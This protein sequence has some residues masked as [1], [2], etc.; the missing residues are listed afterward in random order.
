MIKVEYPFL[1]AKPTTT[2]IKFGQKY[3]GL[4]KTKVDETQVNLLLKGLTLQTGEILT[5]ERIITADFNT[6]IECF[7]LIENSKIKKKL[8]S[9]FTISTR[10]KPASVYENAQGNISEFFMA[11]GINMKSC[12]YCN[13]DFINVF[14]ERFYYSSLQDFIINAPKEV[15]MKITEISEDTARRIRRVKIWNNFNETL[16]K[17]VSAGA[18][19]K[20]RSALND[21][22]AGTLT[23]FDY[24]K[25]IILKNHFTLDHFLPKTDFPYLALSL[26]NLVPSC[27]SCNCKFKGAM[28]FL[29]TAEL[30]LLS[31]TSGKYVLEDELEFK[32][33]FT[34]TATTL[35][36]QIT[37]VNILDDFKIEIENSSNI[38]GFE[39]YL[40]MFKLRGRY[41]FHR[42]DALK[43]IKKR[44]DYSDS[45]IKELSDFFIQRGI[46]K[47][48]EAIKIDLFGSEIFTPEEKNEP[49][50]K[51]KKDIAAQIGILK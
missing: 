33:Y 14:E 50:A 32:I 8:N 9:L 18:Y 19:K 17:A 41:D 27:N 21:D 31:P 26:Y 46:I 7:K 1:G 4:I 24:S 20:L 45:Q 6:L 2:K 10:K 40:N 3:Y 51:Y 35:E 30:N 11:S 49:F 25:I 42:G 44:K 43:M 16:I 5:L 29:P 36:E 34:H 15:L 37:K 39:T 23:H 22:I 13:I 28:E 38:D 47:N 12:H 48:E